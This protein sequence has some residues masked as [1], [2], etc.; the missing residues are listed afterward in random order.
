MDN[1]MHQLNELFQI[2]A[3]IIGTLVTV[4]GAGWWFGWKHRELLAKIVGVG[5]ALET[6]MKDNSVAHKR[7]ENRIEVLCNGGRH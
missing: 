5:T 1:E 3:W 4:I 6:H 7:I 2:V